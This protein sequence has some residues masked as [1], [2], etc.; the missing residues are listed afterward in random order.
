MKY[1]I[2]QQI[3]L[4]VWENLLDGTYYPMKFDTFIKADQALQQHFDQ[5][6]EDVYE[7]RIDTFDH[8]D[9]KIVEFEE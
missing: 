6:E 8:G 1:Q 9:F 2:Q 7:G 3:R 5:L 4:G